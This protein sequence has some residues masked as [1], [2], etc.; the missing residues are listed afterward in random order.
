MKNMHHLQIE[1]LFI[2]GGK[3]SALDSLSVYII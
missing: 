2:K 1:P 3:K